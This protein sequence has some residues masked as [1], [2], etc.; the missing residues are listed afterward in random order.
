MAQM[1][2]TA[3][4]IL[5]AARAFAADPGV[6]S[7]VVYG[8]YSGAA[9]LLDVHRP[10]NPNG[11]GIVYVSGSGWTSAMAYSAA[12][13][14][15]NGQSLQYAKPLVAAGYTVFTVNH[16]ALPRFHYPAAVEDVQRAVRFV[17]SNAAR[18]GIRA[19]RIGAAGGSSGG[20]LVSMLGTLDGKGRPDDRDPVE[21]ES[22]RVQ[23]VVARAAPTNFFKMITAGISFLGMAPT[24]GIGPE[25]MKSQ[26]YRTYYEASPLSHVASGDPP[27][28]LIHGDKD[29]SV[30]FA[31]SEEMEKALKAAGVPVKL[32]RVEG[33][34]HGPTF[35]GAK[36]PPDYLGEMVAWFNRYLVVK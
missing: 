36:N 22:A 30:P 32:I 28:L 35:P 11:Y 27:F 8:M 4:L 26:E 3:L 13:L 6:E 34:G 24:E 21:R 18:F 5:V 12:P 1:N 25:G 7:N 15:S 33:A 2:R 14:K 19:D 31:Q 9:L 29:E 10:A 16:R 17:R 23:C 20:H